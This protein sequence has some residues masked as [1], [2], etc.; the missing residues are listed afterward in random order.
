MGYG[1]Y[2]SWNTDISCNQKKN[3][4]YTFTVRGDYLALINQCF[5]TLLFT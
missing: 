3:T 4:C 5:V 2:A 1:R